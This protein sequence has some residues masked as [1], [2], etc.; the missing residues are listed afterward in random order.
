MF[1]KDGK[2]LVSKGFDKIKDEYFFRSL[3]GSIDFFETSEMGIRR[4]IQEELHSDIENLK[5]IDTIEN[6]FEFE[7]VKRHEIV[8]FYTG[9]LVQ[10][11]LYQQ[12]KIHVIENDHEFDAEWIPVETILSGSIPMY[13]VLDYKSLLS[14]L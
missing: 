12:S 11:E 4:E 5:L 8:F 9:D 2:I 7:G 3:G 6:L 10:K 1:H 13:P 14:E